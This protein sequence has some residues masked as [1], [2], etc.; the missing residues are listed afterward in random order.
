MMA[1]KRSLFP[2]GRGRGRKGKEIRGERGRD[3]KRRGGA[4][5][6]NKQS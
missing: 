6:G 4:K 3:I 1:R 5:E 2:G